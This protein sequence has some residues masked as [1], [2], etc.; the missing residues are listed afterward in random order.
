MKNC[1]KT[2]RDGK[3]HRRYGPCCHGNL[4]PESLWNLLCRLR[5][6]YKSHLS[7]TFHRKGAP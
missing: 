5:D 6:P 7:C 2:R 4:R 1:G 3:T